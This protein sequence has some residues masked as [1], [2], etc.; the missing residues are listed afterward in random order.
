MN[1]EKKKLF[2][3]FEKVC[4]IKL[5]KENYISEDEIKNYLLNKLSFN[6]EL[7]EGTNDVDEHEFEFKINNE[8]FYGKISMI[9]DVECE[10]EDE[11]EYAPGYSECNVTYIDIVNLSIYD[12]F[13]EIMNLD[14]NRIFLDKLNKTLEINIL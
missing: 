2:E 13:N 1:N 14:D 6:L 9:V 11:S 3:A 5:I 8:N 12:N 7:E 10:N 4:K